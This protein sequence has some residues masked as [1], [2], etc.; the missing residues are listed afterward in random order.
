MCTV[1]EQFILWCLVDS[2]QKAIHER[3]HDAQAKILITADA[4]KR[5]GKIFPLKDDVNQALKLS[6]NTSIEKSLYINELVREHNWVEGRDIW[7][8]D[9]IRNQSDSCEPEWVDSEHPYLFYILL[10]LLVL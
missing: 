9:V 8:H 4:Q 3:I 5:G 2:R 1:L 10:V 6:D 7:W